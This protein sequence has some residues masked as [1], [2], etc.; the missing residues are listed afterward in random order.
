MYTETE[1]NLQEIASLKLVCN[2]K[3]GETE[4]KHKSTNQ[5]KSVPA[6]IRPR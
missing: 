6:D 1:I 2:D 3:S 4:S 5:N